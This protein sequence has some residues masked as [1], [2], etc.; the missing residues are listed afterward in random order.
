MH[1][2]WWTTAMLAGCFEDLLLQVHINY[3][4]KSNVEAS[5]MSLLFGTFVLAGLT[6]LVV[7]T[8]LSLK[9]FYLFYESVLLLFWGVSVMICIHINFFNSVVLCWIDCLFGSLGHIVAIHWKV[10]SEYD[11]L[12]FKWPFGNFISGG[13]TRGSSLVAEIPQSEWFQGTTVNPAE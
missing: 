10:P 5:L 8:C 13:G 3:L 9:T 12:G 4:R 1:A 11:L 7:F 2:S 6:V